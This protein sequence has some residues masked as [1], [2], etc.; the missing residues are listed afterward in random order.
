MLSS[1]G[2]RT[3]HARLG[4][5]A[6]R[7][8]LRWDCAGACAGLALDRTGIALLGAIAMVATGVLPM[9]EALASV[10]MPTILLLYAL[11]VV[12]AQLR[13]SGGYT[14]AAVAVS[15][16]AGRVEKLRG[17]SFC[18]VGVCSRTER[19]ERRAYAERRG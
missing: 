18:R 2:A 3:V 1:A 15:R 11:M 13:L 14:A 8:Y 17:R 9:G 10:S 16:L 12:S 6:F 19:T 4:I 5:A 7:R